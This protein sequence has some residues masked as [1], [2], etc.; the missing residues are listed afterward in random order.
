[1]VV[2]V[3]KWLSYG[4]R[5]MLG[6]VIIVY[7]FVMLGK[8]LLS[9]MLLF[10][11]GWSV[12]FVDNGVSVVCF[13]LVWYCIVC[14]FCVLLCS[15]VY[16]MIGECEYEFILL[17][18]VCFGFCLYG[19]DFDWLDNGDVCVDEVWVFDVDDFGWLLV[20]FFVGGSCVL[21]CLNVWL[22]LVVL[23]CGVD[24]WWFVL[25]W[26]VCCEI[27]IFF[28]VLMCLVVWM[29]MC[30]ILILF[31][32]VFVFVFVWIC[33]LIVWCSLLLFFVLL[34]FVCLWIVIRFLDLLCY[35]CRGFLIDL[36]VCFG[37]WWMFGC[38]FLGMCLLCFVLYDCR[39]GWFVIVLM[40]R[41][42]VCY[43]FFFWGWFVGECCVLGFCWI[44]YW[45]FWNF[46][47][48]VW[49]VLCWLV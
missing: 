16:G 49:V 18:V 19:L 31:G 41:I 12:D 43:C 20:I 22:W 21:L 17:G 25:L 42:L 6:C 26:L 5:I 27:V 8:K 3:V 7:M 2:F 30:W 4:V 39:N 38:F 33:F 48:W 23:F 35:F 34:V 11:I 28:W 1:M 40:M 10:V 37:C 24:V 29:G 36:W 44:L 46:F 13:V 15:V 32:F 45:W 14:V 9:G 47:V